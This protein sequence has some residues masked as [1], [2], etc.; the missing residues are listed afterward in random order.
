MA[1]LSIIIANLQFRIFR[2][3]GFIERIKYEKPV[4]EKCSSDLT[5][6]FVVQMKSNFFVAKNVLIICDERYLFQIIRCIRNPTRKQK[7]PGL[8]PIAIFRLRNC[9]TTILV[10]LVYVKT[11][12]VGTT[13][14]GKA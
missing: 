8:M 11:A 1:G 4:Y 3:L 10:A 13:K 7:R 5:V 2:T 12:H 14:S 6:I 9:G